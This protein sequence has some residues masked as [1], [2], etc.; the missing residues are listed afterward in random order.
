MF[1]RCHCSYRGVFVRPL[2]RHGPCCLLTPALRKFAF[3]RSAAKCLTR[4]RKGCV[5]YKIL[6][7]TMLAALSDPVPSVDTC[8]LLFPGAAPPVPPPIY[9][10]VWIPAP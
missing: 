5:F 6:G 3:T 2:P 7:P 8:P 10:P 1:N 9:A 4:P